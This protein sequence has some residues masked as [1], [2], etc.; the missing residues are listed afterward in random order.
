MSFFK[1]LQQI[2]ELLSR[3]SE[4][5]G[6]VYS[7]P[8]NEI[9]TVI[10]VSDP[11][12]LGRVKVEYQDGSTNDWAYVL[13]SGKGVLSAQLI[14]S[15][16]LIGKAS[17]NSGDA[18]VLGFFSKNSDVATG[19]APLQV[20]VIDEQAGAYRSPAKI[21]DQGMRC[22][23]GNSARIYMLQNEVNQDLVVC[24]RRNNPQ[25]GGEEVW[26]WKSL[27][28]GKWIEKG[29]DPGVPSTS[30]TDY[31]EKR[32]IPECSQAMDGDVRDFAEDRKFRT[33]QIKCGKD[34]D[35]NYS[36]KP[37]GATPVFSR[38]LLPDCTAAVHGMDAILD[39]G[40]NS[41]RI[42]CL[43]YQG[44]MKWINPGKREPIQFHR[45]DA[46][47]GKEAFLKS[48]TP[49][50]GLATESGMKAGDS[51]GNSAAEV[52]QMA[53][54]AVPAALPTTP[55]GAALKAANALSGAF[56]GAKLLTDIAKTVIVNNG[57][58]PVDS[59][60]SQISSALGSA[61]V[62]DST[63]QSIL[64]TLGGV[65]DQLLRGAQ[66]GT[67][68]SALENIGKSALNQSI[69]A[70][71]PQASSVY[72]GYM[73]GGIAGAL[74]VASSLNL[75]QIPQ[76]I[77]DVISPALSIG[78]SVL[79]SQ[80]QAINKIISGGLGQAGSTPLNETISSLE[81]IV[82]VT[83]EVAAA[84]SKEINAGSLGEVASTLSSFSNLP[85]M[86]QFSGGATNL[87]KLASTAL[88]AVGLGKEFIGAFSGGIGLESLGSL[89]GV[90]PV[91]GLLGGLAGG[92]LGGGG[93]CPCDPK[94]RKTK[95]FE[96]SDGNSLLEK[97]GNVV[98]N[99]ASS[100]SPD[101]DPTKNNENIVAKALDL[102]PTKLGE[103]LCIPNTSDLTQMIQNV[104]RLGEMADRL[105]S[106]KNADWPELWA[107]MTYTFETI[108][109]AFKQ[110]DN[111]ITKVESIERKLIDGQYRLINKLM[112]GDESF[113]SKTL[114]SIIT[115]SKAIQDVYK[116]VAKLDAKKKGGRAGVFATANLKE[117]FKNIAQ[118]A[119]LNSLS[120]KEASFISNSFLKTADKEWR[121]LEPGGGLVDITKFVLG[122]LPVDVPAVF[123]KCLTKRDKNKSLSDSLQSKINSPAPPVPES[124]FF[125]QLPASI[126]ST[127]PGS[128]SSAV[129]SDSTTPSI[130]SLLE[131]ISYQQGRNESGEA[132]C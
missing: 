10:S 102:I 39:E 124:L 27:T 32:G 121:A 92:L 117:V 29:F 106:A 19:G 105:N 46:P 100:Y 130:T 21:G 4:A 72:F 86:A 11:K 85:G 25:E 3:T 129:P 35:G 67:V 44:Q 54:K 20:A 5:M 16:C 51:V 24:M 94:C 76:E 30:V 110:T 103:E 77:A 126:T 84:I 118:I 104:K 14:G 87:P 33:F 97:C 71:S 15:S 61:G 17:G 79:R 120:K 34:E 73:A 36:W 40:L 22:N 82:P 12:K 122:L 123:D 95:H 42:S 57:T 26:N 2:K 96:D 119:T 125:A 109:K 64:S 81:K 74:D 53:A 59:L 108:E 65:G 116:Y 8:F 66:N 7:D 41:Q 127:T 50:N 75:S 70:L 60:V 38:D 68:D 55:L 45:Q 43:R 18:F 58:L 112:V 98:A 128:L 62:I 131:Q 93:E 101:G 90:N 69:R 28:G 6:G 89:L 13:G 23:K 113:F 88:Q 1:E 9:A 78:A 63:T 115:T 107:E 114:L 80:P 37:G 31:S 47:M 52:L 91:A 99:S 132:Q 49:M 83:S 56:D 48:K 111:N